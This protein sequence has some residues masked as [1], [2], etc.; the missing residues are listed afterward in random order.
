MKEERQVLEVH[1]YYMFM[2]TTRKGRRWHSCLR[3]RDESCA[4]CGGSEADDGRMDFPKTD[5][6]VSRD[7]IGVCGHHHSVRQ[8]TSVDKFDCVMEHDESEQEDRSGN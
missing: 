7:W 3:E 6:V 2:V 1:L 8:R 5:G 4:H